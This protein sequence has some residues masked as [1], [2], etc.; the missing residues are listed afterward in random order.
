MKLHHERIVSDMGMRIKKVR[1]ERGLSQKKIA[2]TLK[3][4]R[5]NIHYYESGKMGITAKYLYD[6]CKLLDV[7]ADYLLFGIGENSKEL[8]E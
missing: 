2:E 1:K 3:C 4:D 7:S 5:K 8:K 6:L